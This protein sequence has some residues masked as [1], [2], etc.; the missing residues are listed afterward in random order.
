MLSLRTRSWKL[1]SEE[2][3]KGQEAHK[4]CFQVENNLVCLSSKYSATLFEE[5]Y[6]VWSHYYLPPSGIEGKVILDIGAGEGETA[7]F[8]LAHGASKVI[9]IE[10]D[11]ANFSQLLDNARRNNWPIEPINISFDVGIFKRQEFDF[12]KMDCE[13]CEDGLLNLST[14]GF[15]ITLEVH[16]RATMERLKR[17]YGFKVSKVIFKDRRFMMNNWDQFVADSRVKPK[18]DSQASNFLQDIKFG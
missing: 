16:S 13:H 17:D 15:P 18:L 10:P 2:G 4:Y 12:V 3:K 5:W 8:F 6:S 1:A 11:E 9:C 14:I 7:L